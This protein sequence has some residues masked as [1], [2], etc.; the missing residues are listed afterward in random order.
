M[1]REDY[2][3][4]RRTKQF[5]LIKLYQYYNRKSSKRVIDFNSFQQVF[6]MYLQGNIVEITKKLDSEFKI[7]VLQDKNGKELKFF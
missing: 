2:L 7:N 5:D 4:M 3:V 1:N 6:S